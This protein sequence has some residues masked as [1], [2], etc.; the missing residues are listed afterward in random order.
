MVYLAV[1]PID[2][3]GATRT[4]NCPPPAVAWVVTVRVSFTGMSTVTEVATPDSVTRRGV[5]VAV[6]ATLTGP[7]AF[8]WNLKKSMSPVEQ[9]FPFVVLPSGIGPY[10]VA[11]VSFGSFTS[12]HGSG[13]G[14]AS[15]FVISTNF[16]GEFAVIRVP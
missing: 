4:K 10:A 7:A 6:T 1:A 14:A 8:A 3:D 9:V 16:C 11:S 13:A 2:P 5:S 15:P 12:L